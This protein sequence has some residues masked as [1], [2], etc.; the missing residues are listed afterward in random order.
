MSWQEVTP[1]LKPAGG[2]PKLV[3]KIRCAPASGLTVLINEALRAELGWIAGLTTLRLLVGRAETEGRI[4]LEPVTPGPLAVVAIGKGGGLVRV[5]GWDGVERRK[6]KAV[7][8]AWT[9]IAET[10]ALELMLPP[11][12]QRPRIGGPVVA[13]AA[14]STALPRTEADLPKRRAPAAMPAAS[15]RD[16]TAA[17][18]GDPP[19]GRSA[20]APRKGRGR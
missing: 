8:V 14:P 18:M 2:G 13:A 16:L 4:R 6:L 5:G 10:A 17:L 15:P 12:L 7:R 19:P 9:A 3:A 11:E 1:A 20:A